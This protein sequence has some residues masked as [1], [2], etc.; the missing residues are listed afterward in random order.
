MKIFN[1]GARDFLFHG[2]RI[3]P[4]KFTEIPAQHEEA[5][6]KLLADYPNELL[7]GENASR[8]TKVAVA[9]AGQLEKENAT[10]K[11]QVEKLQKLLV[12]TDSTES[13][14][15]LRERAE[16]AEARVAELEALLSGGSPAAPAPDAPPAEAPA[17][18]AVHSTRKRR[19]KL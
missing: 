14:T 9:R 12:S 7:A 13:E 8:D 17:A 10:L 5:A 19:E 16:K 15:A 1:K 2:I 3:T 11:A 18:P 6:A 4:D